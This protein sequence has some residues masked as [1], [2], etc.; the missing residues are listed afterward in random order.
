MRGAARG[1]V[2]SALLF[3]CGDPLVD[4]GYRGVPLLEIDGQVTTLRKLPDA[5]LDATL[6]VSVFWA[7]T[8]GGRVLRVVEQDSITTSV[9]FPSAYALRVFEPPGDEH[10]GSAEAAWVV[11]IV[12]VYIDEDADGRF[13]PGVDDIVGGSTRGLLYARSSVP[14]EASPSGFAIE[15]G[16]AVTELPLR[17]ACDA[18]GTRRMGTMPSTAMRPACGRCPPGFVCEPRG[19]GCVVAES[20]D[21]IVDLAFAPLAAICRE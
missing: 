6:G 20:F 15:P 17:G 21:L 8:R 7:P 5:I 14:P 11:G 2:I 9:R 13:D 16:F 19:G 10:F 12:L 18:L 4:A 1:A 3:G